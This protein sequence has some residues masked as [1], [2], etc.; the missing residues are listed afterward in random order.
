MPKFMY[1][2]I[3]TIVVLWGVLYKILTTIPP[4]STGII[5]VFLVLLFLVVTLTISLPTYF[6]FYKKAPRGANLRDTYRKALKLGGYI[7]LGT[8]I[9]LTLGA[10]NLLNPINIVLFA[11]LYALVFKRAVKNLK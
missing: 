5:V 11:V 6:V 2:V 4:E 1:T 3:I 7:G 10:A 8:V 9:F